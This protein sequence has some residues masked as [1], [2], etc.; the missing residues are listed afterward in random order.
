MDDRVCSKH[1]VDGM[2]TDQNLVPSLHIGYDAPEKKERRTL[3]RD[4]CYRA[5]N[6]KKRRVISKASNDVSTPEEMDSNER[7]EMNSND[8][9]ERGSFVLNEHSYCKSDD[10][11][12]CATCADQ[13]ELIKPLVSRVNK[14]TISSNWG[15]FWSGFGPSS[16]IL[17]N[18]WGIPLVGWGFL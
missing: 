14:L 16:G 18:C 5:K 3:K 8:G 15:V 2:P 13:A 17:S 11:K 6:V 10:N 9:S 7:L 12:S 1:F 4:Q